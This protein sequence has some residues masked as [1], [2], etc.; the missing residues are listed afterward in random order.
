VSALS[1][2][3]TYS[4]PPKPVQPTYSP[5]PKIPLPR[6]T[7][8]KAYKTW[9]ERIQYI[10]P[11][12]RGTQYHTAGCPIIKAADNARVVETSIDFARSY[13]L[14]QAPCCQRKEQSKIS[15]GGPV[16]F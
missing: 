11:L 4:P 6:P 3:P 13:N 16:N 9:T 10:G 14:K 7:R 2:Q 12:G 8:N 1:Q 15:S 5:P